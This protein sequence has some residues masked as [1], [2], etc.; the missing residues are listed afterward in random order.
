MLIVNRGDIKIEN[1]ERVA[2]IGKTGCGKTYLAQSLLDEAVSNG[3]YIVVL[4]N[5]GLFGSEKKIVKGVE[6][7]VFT[8]RG[9]GLVDS[10]EGLYKA[11]QMGL[12][13]IVYRPNSDLESND[14]NAF[15]TVMNDFF[16]WIYRREN[17]LLYVDEGTSTTTP[18]YMPPGLT[19]N[20]KRGRELG[21]G[22]WLSTQESVNVHNTAFSQ[23]DHYMVF[24]TQVQA[25]RDKMAG[26][27]GDDVRKIIPD[28]YCFWY[29]HPE[30]MDNA[31][32]H[33]P[34]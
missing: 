17:T 32:M 31:I 34:I 6:T 23:A 16:W 24:R 20:Y 18:F 1:D 28:Q 27:M 25:H 14:K 29:H 19:A 5:K 8:W 15:D 4:D 13:K 9:A 21:I 3:A 2:I 12:K 33:D 7:W 10:F 30:S 26:W 11:S 22:V